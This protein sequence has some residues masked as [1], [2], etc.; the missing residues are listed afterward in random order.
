M[1]SLTPLKML[2]LL[3]CCVLSGALGGYFAASFSPVP[4]QI[5]IVDVQALVKKAVEADQA[6]TE[7]DAKALMTKVKSSTEELIQ[8][9]VVILDAQSVLSA[10]EEAYVNIE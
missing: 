4:A 6:K 1:I 8:R 7:E 3:L 9:G 5:A 2:V 10:P